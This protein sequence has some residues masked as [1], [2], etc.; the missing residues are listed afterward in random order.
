MNPVN[1]SG[2]TFDKFLKT[3]DELYI[4]IHRDTITNTPFVSGILVFT[5]LLVFLVTL[6][7]ISII[8]L[9]FFLKWIFWDILVIIFKLFKYKCS[10]LWK[11]CCFN[12]NYF[13]KVFKKMYTYNF[14]SYDKDVYG[15]IWIILIPISYISFIICN[16]IFCYF[17]NY[18]KEN[19]LKNVFLICIFYL[20]L[21]IEVYISLFYCVKDLFKH[22]KYTSLV[23]LLG[24]FN[25]LWLYLFSFVFDND[26]T[27]QF[28]ER[29]ARMIY[30]IYFLY[31]YIKSFRIV[32][33][34]NM[35]SKYK[36]LFLF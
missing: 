6:F 28:L 20:H 19:K 25:T 15:P 24:C 8:F 18:D 23:F 14:Y 3:I 22:I 35:N 1:I 13:K 32:I 4:Y 11:E 36:V 17:E 5:I 16:L 26:E 30:L 2:N 21:F 34:Y 10:I 7:K 27:F 12:I 29:V 9:C 31:T 33:N